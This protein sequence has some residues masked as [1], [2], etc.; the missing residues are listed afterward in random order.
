MK[1][2]IFSDDINL[3]HW[4]VLKSVLLVLSILPVTYALTHLWAA[5]EGSSQIMVGFFAISLFSSFAIL[6]F[7]SALQ[8]T[9]FNIQK[10]EMTE[11]EQKIVS[12]YRYVPM[13]SFVI[14]V[15]YISHLTFM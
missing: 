5:T 3:F 8:I 15:S 4:T 13:F 2:F 10:F 11:L 12:L 1:A 14:L 7:H 9:V 6:A